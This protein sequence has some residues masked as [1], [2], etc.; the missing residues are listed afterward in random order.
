MGLNGDL[1]ET[2]TTSISWK[3]A[4]DGEQP[5]VVDPALVTD[6]DLGEPEE[7]NLVAYS[8]GEKV[9]ELGVYPQGPEWIVLGVDVEEH[10][11]RLGIATWMLE[12]MCAHLE[13]HG[14]DANIRH[15]NSISDEALAWALTVDNNPE[16]YWRKLHADRIAQIEAGRRPILSDDAGVAV[17][18][19]VDAAEAGI[20]NADVDGIG[21]G[22]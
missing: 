6:R 10:L 20:D 18:D 12:Q 11:R 8:N 2:L 21:R 4:G 15:S 9:G 5:E 13:S 14:F 3:V 7:I 1:P 17:P 22:L 19:A 16:A